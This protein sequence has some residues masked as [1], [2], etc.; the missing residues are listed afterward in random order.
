[1]CHS[2][3]LYAES[4]EEYARI[5]QDNRETRLEEECAW[6][7]EEAIDLVASDVVPLACAA[8]HLARI[9]AVCVSNFGWGMAFLPS[10]THAKPCS[11]TSVDILILAQQRCLQ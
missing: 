1:M 5:A 7:K 2:S 3:R 9:P 10:Q 11:K 8:A 6:L 4:L